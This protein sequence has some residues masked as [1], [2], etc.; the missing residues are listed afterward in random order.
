MNFK[1]VLEDHASLISI[2]MDSM[3]PIEV[4]QL[5]DDWL[6][7]LR[8]I[9]VYQ[10][11]DIDKAQGLKILL[12]SGE[13]L[14][15]GKLKSDHC[16]LIRPLHRD[17]LSIGVDQ[18]FENL[19]DAV[20]EADENGES[21]QRVIAIWLTE[22]LRLLGSNQEKI[23][24]K[25]QR[26]L[27]KD[28]KFAMKTIAQD[29]GALGEFMELF[30][31]FLDVQGELLARPEWDFLDK[32]LETLAKKLDKKKNWR[33]LKTGTI[34]D[35]K[36]DGVLYHLGYFKGAALFV[37]NLQITE[38][39]IWIISRYLVLY[40]M[41]RRL[42]L[43]EQGKEGTGPGALVEEAFQNIPLPM[44]FIGDKDEALQHNTAF[45]KL[46]LAPSKVKKISDLD[47]V[48]IKGQT[49]S[50]RKLE[51]QGSAGQRFI[52]TFLP[53]SSNFS[54]QIV[55]SGQELGIITSSIAHELNNPLAGLLTALELMSMDD[56]WDE[57]SRVLLEEMKEGANR[58]KQLV[59][60]FLGFS[61]VRADA[62]LNLEKGLIKQ[63]AEQ[64]LNLQR[65]RMV[66]SGLRVQLS[67]KQTHPYAYPINAPSLTMAIYLVLGEFMTAHHHLKLL[68]RQAAHGIVIE[69]RVEEDADNFRIIF[70]EQLPKP[71]GFSSK[72]LQYLLQQERLLLEEKGSEFIFS[73]QNVLI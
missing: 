53:V 44:L 5:V 3:H 59:E 72:L 15:Q 24:H 64:A 66:E 36:K 6:K 67:Y 56:H 57:E 50:V 70:S 16:L 41:R 34:G 12:P 13:R 49:W 68:E 47:Q 54:G 51:L 1:S 58:C 23:A 52:F 14:T 63:V 20:I 18:E 8:P 30:T 40:S 2:V 73:H 33:L 21:F 25:N 29:E 28:L 37:E 4:R 35:S 38:N 55:G 22:Y 42:R 39:P 65:F 45:V 32:D 7:P 9:Q 19:A 26:A 60:T 62:S 43:W 46:N 11:S 31:K 10:W 17:L 69:G 61:R 48:I 71:L 27:D